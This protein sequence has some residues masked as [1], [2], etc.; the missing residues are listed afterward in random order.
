MNGNRMILTCSLNSNALHSVILVWRLL[1]GSFVNITKEV[2]TVS[3]WWHNAGVLC[4]VRPW[5]SCHWWLCC[6]LLF[7]QL[8]AS[9]ASNCCIHVHDMVLFMVKC[10]NP[11]VPNPPPRQTWKVLR[12][13]VLFC[14]TTVIVSMLIN[15]SRAHGEV[16][17]GQQVHLNRDYHHNWSKQH[18]M[19]CHFLL[20]C[21]SFTHI[22]V[23][24]YKILILDYLVS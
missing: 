23:F 7:V 16:I 9:R 1:Q 6:T 4:A 11:R 22:S 21:N 20:K 2:H 17:I 8:F 5:L 14:E 13:W 12:P 3:S 18:A 10:G 19:Q 15:S 24:P